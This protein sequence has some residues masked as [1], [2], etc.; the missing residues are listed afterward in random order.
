MNENKDDMI[1]LP[2]EPEPIPDFLKSD[3]W[4]SE[5][6]TPYR[7]DFSK[8][9]EAPRYTLSW[10]GIPFAPLGGIHAITGQAGNGKTMTLAQFMAAILCGEFGSLRYELSGVIPHPR[11][12][13][14]D[15][16]ME[17]ANTIAVKNRVMSI[18]GRPI[19]EVT[20]D[21][22]V[23]MLREVPEST[24]GNG[25]K[26]P[27]SVNRWRMTLKAIYEYQPT[28]VFIDG[29]LDVVR[30]FNDN[31][32]C[33][34]TIYKCMQVASHYGIS[35]WCIVHQ[36]PG[37]EKLVGHLGSFLERKVTDVFQTKKDKNDKSGDVTFTVSQKKAR[38]RDVQDWQF[39]VLPI[40]SWGRPEQ[41]TTEQI[42][43]KGEKSEGDEPE[44][45]R[46]WIE[47]ATERYNWPM[48]R[49]DIK[50]NVFGE[51]GGQLNHDKQNTDLTIALNL[52][53]LEQSTLKKNGS[54][55]L[56]PSEEPPF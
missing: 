26:I 5:D 52:G 46:K 16:E 39:R 3:R 49:A 35:V 17:E 15:T 4:F 25:D 29:L 9:Y 12:L 8:A 18:C 21:F 6:V 38:G 56:Q 13:Y 10:N 27:S 41:I 7:L 40:D 55:M 19:N 36:N 24:D 48:S 14:I 2:R 30:D 45:I 23:V 51:I 34:E 53:Y 31:K 37:G 22:V 54:Y 28:A 42:Q 50:K 11:V 32:E 20:D 1:P 47:Q 44:K 33:Q 43:K